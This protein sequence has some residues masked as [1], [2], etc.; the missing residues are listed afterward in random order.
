MR[1]GRKSSLS[2]V[3]IDAGSWRT[4]DEQMGVHRVTVHRMVVDREALHRSWRY[5]LME[6][7]WLRRN[8]DG[9]DNDGEAGMSVMI[10]EEQAEWGK[11]RE[12]DRASNL[13]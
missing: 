7:S 5:E 9:D 13:M 11:E 8:I 10:G 4:A 12:S 3:A 2:V 6:T 1:A